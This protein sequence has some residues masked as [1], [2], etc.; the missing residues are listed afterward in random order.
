MFIN[1]K[2]GLSYIYNTPDNVPLKQ[3]GAKHEDAHPGIQY[4]AQ[5]GKAN[6]RKRLNI[7]NALKLKLY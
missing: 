2:D 1:I 3:K 4:R 7:K 5:T 6:A